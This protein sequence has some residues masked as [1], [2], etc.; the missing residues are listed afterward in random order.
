MFA[1]SLNNIKIEIIGSTNNIAKPGNQKISKIAPTNANRYT[2]K[3]CPSSQHPDT[4]MLNK[5]TSLLVLE[6][7]LGIDGSFMKFK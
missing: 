1:F 4:K 6:F 2:F 7:L 3:T 5:K